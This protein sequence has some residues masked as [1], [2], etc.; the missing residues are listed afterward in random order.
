MPHTIFLVDFV[1][2]GLGEGIAAGADYSVIFGIG[3]TCGP[4][5]TGHLAD[6][7][8]FGPALRLAFLIEAVAVLLPWL[9]LSSLV[10]GAFVTGTVPLV[11]SRIGELLPHHPA[12]QKGAWSLATTCFALCQAAAYGLSFFFDASDEDYRL[13]F[14]IGTAA[15]VVALAIDLVAAVMARRGRGAAADCGQT[16]CGAG[17]TSRCFVPPHSRPRTPRRPMSH[18]LENRRDRPKGRLAGG[19]SGLWQGLLYPLL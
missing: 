17:Q 16:P 5:L 1:A 8:G 3:A 9:M 6:R 12:E 7:S 15:M 2:R 14:F 11:L 19:L 4:V 18:A 13:L 10:V